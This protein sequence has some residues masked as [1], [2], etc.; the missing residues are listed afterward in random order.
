MLTDLRQSLLGKKVLLHDL[1]HTSQS[2]CTIVAVIT[3]PRGTS[4][5]QGTSF[6]I[7]LKSDICR[8]RMANDIIGWRSI[9][10]LKNLVIAFHRLP[11]TRRQGLCKLS[12]QLTT[13]KRKLCRLS[14]MCFLCLFCSWLVIIVIILLLLLLLVIIIITFTS[15]A[16]KLA[17]IL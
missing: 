17:M 16:Y 7:L 1:R 4:T 2:Y 9:T 14:M 5:R 15:R 10:R 11:L 8:Q 13:F 6:I 3:S 12:R